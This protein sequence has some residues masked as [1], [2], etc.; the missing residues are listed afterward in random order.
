MPNRYVCLR[1]LFI[2]CFFSI[3]VHTQNA[4]NETEL[5]KLHLLGS[6]AANKRIHTQ[7]ATTKV[8]APQFAAYLEHVLGTCLQHLPT[9]PPPRII[10]LIEFDPTDL[11]TFYGAYS[12]PLQKVSVN[13]PIIITI[14][15]GLIQLLSSLNQLGLLQAIIAHELSHVFLQTLDEHEADEHAIKILRI[16]KEDM[17]AV[18][19]ISF[20]ATS[21]HKHRDLPTQDD[22]FCPPPSLE[23]RLAHIQRC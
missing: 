22:D 10:I 16:S 4:V 21:G 14:G 3:P 19:R 8:E 23:A 12:S 2:T 1:A 20:A 18:L 11:H 7:D 13:H 17:I 6:Q 15:F 9:Q 5:Q